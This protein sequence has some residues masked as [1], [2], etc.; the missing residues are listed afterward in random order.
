MPS[1]DGRAKRG[2]G[3]VREGARFRIL[4]DR[5]S[6]FRMFSYSVL[7][8]MAVLLTLFYINRDLPAPV[9]PLVQMDGDIYVTSQLTTR[10]LLGLRTRHIT[11]V[12]DLRPDGEAADQTSS[13]DMQKAMR[14][15]P[16]LR[17]H[18][19]P[20]PHETI[21]DEAVDQL[22]RVLAERK[23]GAVLYC[24][25]GRRAART[26]ALVEASRPGGP[27]VERILSMVK[28]A[29]FTAEDLKGKIVERISHRQ[30]IAENTI[31]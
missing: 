12:V 25:S 24:R 22:G 8:A 14:Y 4:P 20:I 30:P 16:L 28:Q 13:A 11:T 23:G 5:M 1:L 2:Q 15:F 9:L 17:F 3:W 6:Y 18:Y 7:G 26:F 19:I 27:G 31:H 29:G 21:P 10:N